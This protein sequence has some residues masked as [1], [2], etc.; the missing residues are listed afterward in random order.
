[1]SDTFKE[2]E[3][4]ALFV[5]IVILF[6]STVSFGAYAVYSS[7]KSTLDLA[8]IGY[9]WDNRTGKMLKIEETK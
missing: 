2:S 5:L 1:V 3:T 7:N 8:K 9:Y 4:I 6:L